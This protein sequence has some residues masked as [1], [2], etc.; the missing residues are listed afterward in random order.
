MRTSFKFKKFRGSPHAD[1]Y[2]FTLCLLRQYT[3]K[4][5]ATVVKEFTFYVTISGFTPS[6]FVWIWQETQ[7]WLE[8]Q[9]S[10]RSFGHFRTPLNNSAALWGSAA[11]K[12]GLTVVE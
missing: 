6:M 10:L 4:N 9:D 1:K 2:T 3:D 8:K 7:R 11:H 12:L 5:T